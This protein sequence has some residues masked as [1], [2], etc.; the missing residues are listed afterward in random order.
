[1]KA[2]SLF[3]DDLRHPPTGVNAIEFV[4]ARSVN[5]AIALIENRPRFA[6]FSLD[7]DMG[8]FAHDGGDVI[9]LVDYLITREQVE[10]VDLW[11]RSRIIIH[12]A[13]PVGV[14]NIIRA[15]EKWSPFTRKGLGPEGVTL[16]R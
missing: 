8:E 9:A 12:S 7:H 16:L 3:V 4:V 11:P 15:L 6:E 10:G 2:Y 13:N 14:D 5:K 1:M